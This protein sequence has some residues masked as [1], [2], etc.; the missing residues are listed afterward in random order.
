MNLIK[1]NIIHPHPQQTAQIQLRKLSAFITR[2]RIKKMQNLT[3]SYISSEQH[4]YSPLPPG[5]AYFSGVYIMSHRNL[6]LHY[7]SDHFFFSFLFDSRG[8]TKQVK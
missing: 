8:E 7:C 5:P 2:Q 1:I 3:L 6:N 4:P